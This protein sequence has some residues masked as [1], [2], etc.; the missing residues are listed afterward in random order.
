MTHPLRG[1][2]KSAARAAN[3]KTSPPAPTEQLQG[4]NNTDAGNKQQHQL[5][6]QQ[7]QQPQQQQSRQQHQQRTLLD[8]P[9]LL[10]PDGHAQLE[11]AVSEDRGHDFLSGSFEYQRNDF[12]VDYSAPFARELYGA[13]G[14][15]QGLVHVAGHG[16][17][18]TLPVGDVHDE[19]LFY[20]APDHP[21]GMYGQPMYS[22]LI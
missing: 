8:R 18:V 13:Y 15:D 10:R 20:G 5:H 3:T 17:S 11:S 6:H 19:G 2:K 7:Q 21:G 14:G 16:K 22:A 1:G 12:G 9:S 4:T